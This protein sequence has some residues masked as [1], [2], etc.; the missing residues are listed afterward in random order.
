MEIK[1]GGELTTTR[2]KNI[3]TNVNR[4]HTSN[5]KCLIIRISLRNKQTHQGFGRLS[6]GVGIGS[7]ETFERR[8]TI[9]NL[10]QHTRYSITSLT[11]L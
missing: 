2:R 6:D 1:L 10:W 11:K 7:A 4:Y 3:P 5:N 8:E 9:D